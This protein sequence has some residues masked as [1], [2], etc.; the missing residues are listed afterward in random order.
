MKSTIENL[1][2]IFTHFDNLA[3]Q[4]HVEKIKTIG[5]AYMVVSGAPKNNGDKVSLSI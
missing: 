3:E 1:N 2:K 4:Y 5:D